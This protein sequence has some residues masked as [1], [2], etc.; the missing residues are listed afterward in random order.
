MRWIEGIPAP[1]IVEAH[2]QAHPDTYKVYG[3]PASGTI[4]VNT[5]EHQYTEKETLVSERL[6]VPRPDIAG[7]WLC[8]IPESVVGHRNARLVHLRVH[9][10]NRRI[11]SAVGFC[12]EWHY[13]DRAVWGPPSR[14]FPLTAEGLPVDYKA[15]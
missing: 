9:P 11:I 13:L 4:E 6:M 7:L 8:L 15:D 2:M 12:R 1:D 14:Y 5:L 10:E 3:N